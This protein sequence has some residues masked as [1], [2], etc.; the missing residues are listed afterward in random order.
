[1]LSICKVSGDGGPPQV[2]TPT[3]FAPLVT[4]LNAGT[5][6][7]S[8]SSCSGSPDSEYQLLFGYA[9]GP[10]VLVRFLPGCHPAISNGS[11]AAD[12]EAE[13]MAELTPLLTSH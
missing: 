5:T 12:N 7:E 6:Q 10:P 1:T 9:E 13:V 4:A 3:N 11:L 2:F 8:D